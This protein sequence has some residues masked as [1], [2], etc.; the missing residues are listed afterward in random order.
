MSDLPPDLCFFAPR[1]RLV[2]SVRRWLLTCIVLVLG[3]TLSTW[4][5]DAIAKPKAKARPVAK[6]S[7]KASKQAAAKRP[8]TKSGR[9]PAAAA[10]RGHPQKKSG[11]SARKQ[12]GHANSKVNAAQAKKTA[13]AG[14]KAAAA[15]KKAAAAQAAA[16]SKLQRQC[17]SKAAAKTK[18]CRT[19][20][21]A[22][23]VRVAEAAHAKLIAQCKSPKRAKTSQ[24]KALRAQQ[25]RAKHSAEICG[26]RFG[27]AK[28]NESVAAFAKRYRVREGDVRRFN[29]IGRA[30]RLRGGKRYVVFKSPF[31]GERLHDGVLLQPIEDVIAM[32][33]PERGWGR[34]ALVSAIVQAARAVQTAEPRAT[35]LVVGDLSKEGGGC[36]PPHRSHRGGLDAD[37][38]YFHL[39]GK[40]RNWLG[41]ATPEDIDPDRT[42]Q[43]LA[44]L[45]ATG[46]LRYAFI[47]YDLQP[48]LYAAAL[49][50][51]ETQA[52]LSAMFQ[53]PR[54]REA[55]KSGVIRHLQG[56]ADHMH[57]RLACES[58]QPCALS[59]E[60][61]ATVE[62]TDVPM[63]G[64]VG[65]EG[66]R[67]Q[68]AH[69]PVRVLPRPL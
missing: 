25:A 64:R 36:L 19:F 47:D 62:T 12:S 10:K 16:R 27:R 2:R 68:L 17:K 61:A 45:R 44:A 50:A 23:K 26:R 31:E 48:T 69:T 11:A 41:L 24:C 63:R 34:A 56:H 6:A 18:T 30:K 54:P 52:N 57:V 35:S 13:A 49:R 5:H 29:D 15:A 53:Y 60:L 7:G 22:E 8:A 66:R 46:R 40:Q 20:F 59:D 9:A 38:G 14:K 21:A 55:T 58:G 32:Q 67:G 43:F 51:G 28:K 65:G 42:W 1:T 37:I 4:R 39:G 33:R 3:A